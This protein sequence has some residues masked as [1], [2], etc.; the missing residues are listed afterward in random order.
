MVLVGVLALLVSACTAPPDPIPRREVPADSSVDPAA[1]CSREPLSAVDD[2]PSNATTESPRVDVSFDRATRTITLARGE[3]V[4]IPALSQ[5]VNDSLLREVEPGT[6]LLNASITVRGGASLQISA[7][8]VR[9]LRMA[10][11]DGAVTT[12]TALGGGISVEGSCIT[13]WNDDTQRVDEEYKDGRS[14]LLARDGATMTIDDAELRFLGSG[15]V[16]GE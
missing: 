16:A 15:A 12:L 2:A 5:E 14:Y 1:P 4:S 3:N 7:P 11:G 8:D 9:W 13:S 10:S 6:W